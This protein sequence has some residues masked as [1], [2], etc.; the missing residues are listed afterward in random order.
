MNYELIMLKGAKRMKANALRLQT[1]AENVAVLSYCVENCANSTMDQIDR[2]AKYVD[3]RDSCMAFV[4]GVANALSSMPKGYSA[5][6]KTVY[7]KKSDKNEL[8][9]KYKI[10]LSTFYRKLER[11][12]SSFR[13]HLNV[14]GCSEAWFWKNFG[15]V[16]WI[17]SMKKAP[18]GGRAAL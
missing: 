12:R 13:T 7:L 18:S 10:S 14:C 1:E 3:M 2:I 9:R 16:S 11:A 4:E 5:L 17:K 8:C 15:D 6:L